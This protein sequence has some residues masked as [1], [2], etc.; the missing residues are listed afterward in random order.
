MKM[1]TKIVAKSHQELS[2]A[3]LA[4]A[5]ALESAGFC[6]G[7]GHA[8][9]NRMRQAVEV[10]E[11]FPMSEGTTF[12]FQ[13]TAK[14]MGSAELTAQISGLE[15]S[16]FSVFFDTFEGMQCRGNCGGYAGQEIVRPTLD[17]VQN[18]KIRPKE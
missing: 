1:E 17:F 4:V 8:Y 2:S 15:I 12:Q 5:T 9:A 10:L 7:E 11:K 3:M 13:C 14:R 18:V 6:A 16:V